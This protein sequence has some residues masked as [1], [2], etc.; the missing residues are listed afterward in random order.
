MD[1]I[2]D[3]A[4]GIVTRLSVLAKGLV[5]GDHGVV[6]KASDLF[7]L[8][9][10]QLLTSLLAKAKQIRGDIV[11]QRIIATN[12]LLFLKYRSQQGQSMIP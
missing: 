12:R 10:V 2:A 8:G 9:D 6:D 1:P 7:Q 4:K 5:V 11:G 3:F